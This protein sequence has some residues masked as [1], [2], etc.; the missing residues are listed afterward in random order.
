MDYQQARQYIAAALPFGWKLG[1]ERMRALMAA[2]GDPQ[3][4]LRYIHVAGT[5]GKGS[6]SM[7]AACA[8]AAADLRTG[9]FTSPYI[10]RFTERIRV[11]AGRDGLARLAADERK[12]EIDEVDFAAL[13]TRVAAA[14]TDLTAQGMEQPTEFEL[15]TAVAL[16][17]FA[18]C[19][20]DYVV[21]EVGLGGRFDSTN[22]IARAEVCVITALGYDHTDRL[23]TTMTEI[24]SNKA[25]II[26]PASRTVLYDPAAASDNPHDAAAVEGVVRAQCERV[27]SALTIV[28]AHQVETLCYAPDGQQFRLRHDERSWTFHTHLLGAHQPLNAAVAA[29]AVWPLCGPQAVTA[30][31]A[32]TRWP[33]RQELVR[34]EHPPLLIDGSH[35]PQSVR[36]LVATLERLFAGREMIFV[37]GVMA[38]KEHAEMLRLVLTAS[39]YRV[40]T[41]IA[42]TPDH[43]RAMPAAAL[44]AEARAVWT[45]AG[46]EKTAGA[47]YNDA[48]MW[49]AVDDPVA[50]AAQAA[51]MAQARDGVLCVFGSLYMVG[52]VR[53]R[54]RRVGT[55][56]EGVI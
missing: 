20:C 19:A 44:C 32:A 1:L 29:T 49:L 55:Q 11:I 30:G 13:V 8:L 7:Y 42:V 12:G 9:L 34:R 51:R 23:G 21:L 28:R 5:N 54:W 37:C 40:A 52:A 41:F 56:P 31:I 35:N 33:A 36:Q 16:L 4:G 17:H 39:R 38:D 3:D 27:G 53:S 45:A 22:V 6:T 18:A 50:G 46:L 24:A 25:G 48:N 10:E 47:D 43:P 15:I 2:L 14:V 26:K